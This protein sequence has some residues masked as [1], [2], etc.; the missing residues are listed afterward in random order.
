MIELVL[1]IVFAL[2]FILNLLNISG[3]ALLLVL[4]GAVLSM[5]YFYISVILFNGIPFRRVMKK[6]AYAGISKLRLI[7]SAASGV[8]LSVLVIGFLFVMM[9]WPGGKL[10]LLL[11]IILCIALMCIALYKYFTKR[12]DFYPALIRRLTVWIAAGILLYTLPQNVLIGIK[13]RNH[14]EYRDALLNSLDNPED[15]EAH[16]RLV[17]EAKKME[18]NK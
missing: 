11:G 2:G 6:D 8:A 16:Q 7:G 13:Y 5:V 14:P 15:E 17:D 3:G 18:S 9:H 1:V 12:G 10:M 4:S